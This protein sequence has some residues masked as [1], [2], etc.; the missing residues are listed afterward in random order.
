MAYGKLLL[1][2]VLGGI[3]GLER[4]A[5]RKPVGVRTCI[6]ISVTTCILT[7]V[8]ISAAEY[9]AALSANIRT[10][11]MRLAAQV[12]SGIGFLG[13]GVILHKTND[14]ISGITTAAMIWVSA[15]MGIAIGAGFYGDAIIVSL[16]ILLVLRYSHYVKILLP[17]RQKFNHVMI[18]LEIPPEMDVNIISERLNKRVQQIKSIGI[19]EKNENTLT[20]AIQAQIPE[21]ETSYSIYKELKGIEQIQ[22]IEIKYF[23]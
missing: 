16:I 7:I 5:K 11:P 6:I 2:I 8:S 12:V 9:Y 23:L 17:K 13:T 18:K 4:E 14:M 15:A 19:K 1:A 21:Q 10:D 3:I 22:A 20:I